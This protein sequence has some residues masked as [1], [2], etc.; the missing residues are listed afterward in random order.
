MLV[1]RRRFC[2][3][4]LVVA[5]LQCPL[6]AAGPSS[7]KALAGEQD[8]LARAKDLYGLAAYDEALAML[9]RLHETASPVVSSEVAGYQM[10]CLLALG[11]TDDAQKAIEALVKADPLYRP[12]ESVMSPRTLARFEAVRRELLPAIVQETYDKGKAAFDRKDLRVAL[13]EFD[14]IIAL[15][16]EPGL[17][18][19]P[20]MLDLRRLA[21]GFRDLSKAAVADVPASPAAAS[22]KAPAPTAAA[23]TT[24]PVD[25]TP[26]PARTYTGE[27]AGVVPP[28]VVSR[29][30]PA[31]TPRNEIEKRKEFRGLLEL[32]VDEAGDVTSAALARSIHPAYDQ[33]LADSARTWKFRPAMKDGVPVKYR[34]TIEFRLGPPDR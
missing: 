24:A 7:A 15:L 2:K 11:R 4:L 29:R 28:M 21:I 13:A 14:R 12:S 1:L 18:D 8:T 26:E 33:Q 19:V 16:E 6:G 20:N 23:P 17:T 22:S 30:T 3:V 32:V 10:L 9:D 34:M 25:P 31:W 5:C 27:D